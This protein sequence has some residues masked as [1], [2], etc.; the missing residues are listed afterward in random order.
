[1]QQQTE[2]KS[3]VVFCF[4]VD[5]ISDFF[6]LTW[7]III[8]TLN[9]FKFLNFIIIIYIKLHCKS[10]FDW[11]F[12]NFLYEFFFPHEMNSLIYSLLNCIYSFNI[13]LLV[14]SILYM[15]VLKWAKLASNLV[16]S[17]IIDKPFIV[18]ERLFQKCEHLW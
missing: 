8:K 9:V 1:M 13:F 15:A 14:Y 10:F 4:L 6:A 17:M 18:C 11:F 7:N 2:T 12:V 3:D 5:Y 16:L